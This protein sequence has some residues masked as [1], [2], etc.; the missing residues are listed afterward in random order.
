MS[1]CISDVLEVIV[2]KSQSVKVQCHDFS[3][4]IRGEN[5]CKVHRSTVGRG[6]QDPLGNTVRHVRN[7]FDDGIT[8]PARMQLIVVSTWQG[9]TEGT[10]TTAVRGTSLCPW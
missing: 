2:V 1:C 9:Q 3:L 8:E 5:F 10:W 6:D 4:D 7:L